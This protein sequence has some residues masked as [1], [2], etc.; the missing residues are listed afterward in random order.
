LNAKSVLLPNLHNQSC[1]NCEYIISFIADGGSRSIFYGVYKVGEVIFGD[2]E[3][4]LRNAEIEFNEKKK[5][6]DLI[7]DDLDKGLFD[8]VL[9]RSFFREARRTDLE[10]EGYSPKVHS[11]GTPLLIIVH[12]AGKQEAW[13]A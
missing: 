2:Y 12:L 7:H 10:R 11:H 5:N 1:T 4:L 8:Q 13:G 3:Q 9:V 6:L